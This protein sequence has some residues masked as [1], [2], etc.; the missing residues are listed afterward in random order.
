[1]I[2]S[3]HMIGDDRGRDLEGKGLDLLRSVSEY[4]EPLENHCRRL[5]DFSLALG[6]DRGIGLDEDLV[7]CACY[8]HDIGLCITHPEE[9][10]YLRRGLDFALPRVK[11]WGVRGDDLALFEEIM[12]YN[13]S[14]KRVPG[15]DPRA[16]M[17]RLAVGVEHSFGVRSHGLSKESRRA[18]FARHPRRGFNKVLM[19][20]FKTT[21]VDDG[22]TQ[23]FGIFLPKAG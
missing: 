9:R 20:F 3:A 2:E 12:L 5:A 10:N 8:L 18:V 14:L 21:L 16:E 19:S 15:L 11:E 22:P 17:V 1:M 4:G 7:R 13:H 6:D 23:V